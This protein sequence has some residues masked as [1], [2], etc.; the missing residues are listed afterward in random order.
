MASNSGQGS[1]GG[2]K[3]IVNQIVDGAKNLVHRLAATL[4]QLRNRNK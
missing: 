1:T 3:G 2:S 4:A